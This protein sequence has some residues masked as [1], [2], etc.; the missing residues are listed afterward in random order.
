MQTTLNKDKSGYILMGSKQQ[1][2][3]ARKRIQDNPMV[4]GDFVMKELMEEKW[5]G[6]YL[7]CGLRESVKVTIERRESKTRRASFEIVNIVKDYR[8]QLTGGFQTGLVLWESCVIPSLLYK[9][10]TWVEVGKEE[11]KALEDQQDYFLRLLWGAGPGT[12]REALRADTATRSMVSRIYKEKVMLLYH[13]SH[14]EVG[15]LA[16]DI[17]EEQV[18]HGW[19]G[20]VLKVSKLCDILGLVDAG[21]TSQDKVSYGKEVKRACLWWDEARMKEA[22]EGK[23][24]K[25]MRTMY[26]DNLDMKDYVRTGS[27]YTARATWEVRSHML[28]VAGNYPGHMKYA[29]TG[30][31]CQACSLEVREDQEHLARCEGYSDFR[32]GKDLTVESELVDFIKSVMARR[33]QMNWD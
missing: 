17:M 29:A 2:E 25:K 31:R 30:W 16:R 15:D 5:L 19:P 7:A 9:C 6:D 1:V 12:P 28:R 10:S 22:M 20:L 11:E 13:I 18:R 26:N 27:L 24:D 8:A 21:T 32:A 23:K 4:C 3:E 33:K 14:L